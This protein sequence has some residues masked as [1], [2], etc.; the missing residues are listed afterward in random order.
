M[1]EN[2]Y[3]DSKWVFAV[4]VGAISGLTALAYMI[5]GI[6]L[7]FR[8]IALLFAWDAIIVLL[9]TVCSGIFGKMYLGENAEM[10]QGIQDMKVAAWFD[11]ANLLFWVISAS[12]CG[13][14]VFV[15]NRTLL[16]EGRKKDQGKG[17]DG[18]EMGSVEAR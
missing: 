15:A 18:G 13:Y 16:T 4:T 5:W 2:V 6:F 8:A 10:D 14:V 12:Y 7:E 9:W 1:K 17:E 3:A 11:L